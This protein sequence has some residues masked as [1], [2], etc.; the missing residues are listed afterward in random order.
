MIG[1]FENIE[2]NIADQATEHIHAKYQFFHMIILSEIIMT[3]GGSKTVLA[4]LK[5]AAK[6]RK[7]E[8]IV[9]ES[10]PR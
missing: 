5:A 3:Y 6:K 1:Q 7:F 9:A 8:V 2:R 4:F 10:A